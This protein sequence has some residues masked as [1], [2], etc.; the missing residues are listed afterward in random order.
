MRIL[1]ENT[2]S[3]MHGISEMV[4]AR[5]YFVR[6]CVKNS[7]AASEKKLRGGEKN[8]PTQVFLKSRSVPSEHR[9]WVRGGRVAAGRLGVSRPRAQTW[10]R[11]R[12][13]SF[14][15]LS[16]RRPQT[17]RDAPTTRHGHGPSGW[18]AEKG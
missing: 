3:T 5:H 9:R 10:G 12:P 18:R 7:F 8:L 2:R 11:P 4:R 6:P 13:P 14:E 15:N 17:P 16:L 1:R